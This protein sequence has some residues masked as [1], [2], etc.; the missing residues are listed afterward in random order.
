[1]DCTNSL[2]PDENLELTMKKKIPS[3][4]PM[5]EEVISLIY[6]EEGKK[7]LKDDHQQRKSVGFLSGPFETKTSNFH[8]TSESE[9]PPYLEIVVD[10]NN[11]QSTLKS[12]EKMFDFSVN[13]ES[14]S[15]MEQEIEAYPEAEKPRESKILNTLKEHLTENI[16]LSIV[17]AV[18]R[19][20]IQ[21]FQD[22]IDVPPNTFTSQSPPG[23]PEA[24]LEKHWF[25]LMNPDP[26]SLDQNSAVEM[27]KEAEFGWKLR[28][29]ERVKDILTAEA[30][31]LITEYVPLPVEE[32]IP[33]TK[34]QQVEIIEDVTTY[35]LSDKENQN[36]FCP[37]NEP[38]VRPGL[39]AKYC[40]GQGKSMDEKVQD[41]DN[42]H[43]VGINPVSPPV[44]SIN[45]S[46]PDEAILEI[47]NKKENQ[48]PLSLVAVE[49][50][51]EIKFLE[52]H[53]Q[54]TEKNLTSCNVWSRRGKAA[55]PLQI[56]T[57]KSRVKGIASVYT[58]V[59]MSNEKDNVNKAI[60]QDSCSVLDEDEEM[61]DPD[62]ENFSPNTLQLRFQKNKGKLEEIKHYKSQRL[63][64]SKVDVCANIYP[65]ECM[66]P[67]SNKENQT[68]KV[69]QGQNPEIRLF[70]S[71]IKLEPEQDVVALKNR[72]KSVPIQSLLMHAPAKSRSETSGNVSA[73]KNINASN[74]GEILNKQANPSVS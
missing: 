7:P 59:Q 17:E 40:Q 53:V 13:L 37:E 32:A 42:K 54:A 1:M 31:K 71:H 15:C 14:Q 43:T 25:G 70:C 11:T 66:S 44:A 23:N 36:K 60:L 68:L 26:A 6:D 49:G 21:Q 30:G 29:D 65:D 19:T 16:C 51:S 48:S 69:A 45:S 24:S 61:F 63:H 57:S 41:I 20:K 5:V 22:V 35:S 67:T 9:K 46:L 72:V 10:C 28:K 33:E 58:E 52:S 62:K 47:K 39:S 73:A 8:A 64:N 18:Q 56:G 50:C 12:P 38:M 3:V 27:P 34:L 55:S 74:C 2:L 4:P